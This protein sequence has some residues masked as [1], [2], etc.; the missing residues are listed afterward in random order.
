MDAG[1]AHAGAASANLAPFTIA[2]QRTR[3]KNE[4]HA[5]LIAQ[6][7]DRCRASDLFGKKGLAWLGV[8]PLPLD[9]RL[10]LEQRL[11]ELDR[12]GEDLHEV[13]QALAQTT[14]DDARLRVM[15][16]IIGVNTTV[17]IGLLSAIGDIERFPNP[18]KAGELLRT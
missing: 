15:L 1:R 13:D 3:L 17:A 2:S 8:Q 10:S 9:E 4:I 5:V 18:Q 11:R 16:T 7:I 14:I 6:L 12:L